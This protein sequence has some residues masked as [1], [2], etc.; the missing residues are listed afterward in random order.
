MG[1]VVVH[2]SM[3]VDGYVA[4]PDVSEEHPLGVGGERLHEWMFVDPM[5]PT[6]A[7][8]AAEAFSTER[9]GAVLMGRTTLTVGLRWWGDDGTYRVP[10][11]VVTHRPA[12]TLVKGP[13][14]FAFVTDGLD[15]AL[16]QARAAAG[17]RDVNVMGAATASQLLR[18]GQVDRVHLNLVPVLLGDGARLF[19][20]VPQ[21]VDL[22]RTGTV[23]SSRADHLTYRVG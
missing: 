22:E 12:E 8:V 19:D 16:A 23:T 15:S 4:G 3:S 11:F 18:A 9:V 10:C 17:D 13:T 7:R 14:S 1:D 6:D 5:D 21:G 2:M 20:G